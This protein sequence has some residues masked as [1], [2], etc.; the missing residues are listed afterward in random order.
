M[1]FDLLYQ[2]SLASSL[3]L[4]GLVLMLGLSLV[5][6]KLVR[7]S[8]ERYSKEREEFY[9]PFIL[10]AVSAEPGA[11]HKTLF[12]RDRRFGDLRIVENALLRWV[13][14]L[15]GQG[16]QNVC[17][18]F[19]ESG[20]AQ[21]EIR[22]LKSLRWWIRARAAQRLGLMDCRQAAPNLLRSLEDGSV[23]VR[24]MASWALGRLGDPRALSQI[25]PSLARHSR[26]AALR[27]TNTILE[28]GSRTLPV[29]EELLQSRDPQ[30]Q[31]LAVSR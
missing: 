29:L 28:M 6:T 26:L 16:R 30:V 9:K 27:V 12:P 25:V 3:I 4:L 14:G 21:R 23:E 5:L 18:L 22:R 1:E 17:R 19:Q 31:L 20:F 2:L 8:W 13:Q 24:L 7:R 11:E 15:S 10:Q